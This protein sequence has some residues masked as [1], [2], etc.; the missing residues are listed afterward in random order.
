[1]T[2]EGVIYKITGSCGKVYIGS[3]IDYYN[4]RHQHT[5]CDTSCSKKLKKPLHFEV[6]RKDGYKLI[7][8]MLLVEQY[9]INIYKCVNMRRA[10]TNPFIREK[11]RKEINKANYQKNK[12]KINCPYCNKEG[13]N[14]NL[15]QHQKSKSCK[16]VQATKQINLNITINL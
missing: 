16:A 14:K 10:Y 8:T 1:M 15:K 7:K 3:T 2:F 6:I 5:Y 12:Q 4:R 9:Y 11:L 13:Y